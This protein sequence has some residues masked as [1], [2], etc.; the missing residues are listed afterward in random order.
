MNKYFKK[1]ITSLLLAVMLVMNSS[2]AAIGPSGGTEGTIGGPRDLWKLADSTTLVPSLATFV[3]GTVSNPIANGFFTAL[4]VGT[5]TVSIALGSPFTECSVLFVDGSNNIAEDNANFCFD[6][7][8]DELGIGTTTPDGKLHAHTAT[9]GSVTANTNADEIIA[10][11]NGNAGIS[12]LTP[13]VNVGGVRWSSP[14]ADAYAIF[15]A[16]QS[17]GLVQFG[18]NLTGGEIAL[19]TE[20]FDEAVRIDSSGNV[21]IGIVVP[22]GTLHTHTASAGSVTADS[23]VDDL[24][25]ENS[26]GAGITILTPDA[27]I[28]AIQFKSPSSVVANALFQMQNTTGL[29]QFGTALASGELSFLSGNVVE[30]IRVDSSGN[31]GIGTSLP[32][33][34]LHID[35]GASSELVQEYDDSGGGFSE[36]QF[37]DADALKWAM[38]NNRSSAGNASENVLYFWQYTDK[39]DVAVGLPRMKIDDAGNV[40]IG[41]GLVTA[42]SA[43]LNVVVADTESVRA[44]LFTQNDTTNDPNALK[45]IT[46]AGSVNVL[47][48]STN[49]FNNGMLQLDQTSTGDANIVFSIGDS[50]SKSIGVDNTDADKLKFSNSRSVSTGTVMTFNGTNVGIGTTTAGATL[51]VNGTQGCT[52]SATQNITAGGGITGTN[53]VMR[54][55]GSGGAVTITAT[56]SIVDGSDGETIKIQGDSDTNTL[57]IQGEAQLAGSGFNCNGGL[58][59]VLGKGDIIEIEYDLGDDAWYCASPLSD[60]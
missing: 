14:S 56:P 1:L 53:C 7:A 17:T 30:A 26:A 39:D 15:Q 20:S 6:D 58:D 47:I 5:L 8:A 42:V 41:V 45:A 33:E 18:A 48:E 16:Q 35:G 44:G 54:V 19:M 37:R 3:L 2:A 50:N 59:V 38:G 27:S 28:G 57:T 12:I 46:T 31:V 40:G 13:D 52:P 4:T 51:E 21:G 22:D 10:E 29:F 32:S 23:N 34:I 36:Y 55:Q 60:N 11:N 24:V 49:T 25:V 43:R 9:A